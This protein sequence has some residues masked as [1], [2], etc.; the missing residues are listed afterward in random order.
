MYNK[1]DMSVIAY[2]I[3][4]YVNHCI[5]NGSFIDKRVLNFE[6]LETNERYFYSILKELQDKNYVDDIRFGED[7]SFE[8]PYQCDYRK[9]RVTLD[10]FEYME[11]KFEKVKRY[12]ADIKDLYWYDK[13]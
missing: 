13:I 1:N 3:L 7:F 6:T 4:S 5:K 2:K 9:V 10:G 8:N 11:T 12:L